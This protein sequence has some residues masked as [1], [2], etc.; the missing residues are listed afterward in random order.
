MAERVRHT[1]AQSVS[2]R[3]TASIATRV[4]TRRATSLSSAEPS[5]AAEAAAAAVCAEAA[6]AAEGSAACDAPTTPPAR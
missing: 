3:P 5:A 4:R 1:H 6:V 2:R